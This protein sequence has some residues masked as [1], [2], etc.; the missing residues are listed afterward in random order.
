MPE[1]LRQRP[2]VAQVLW[3][4]LVPAAFGALC[5][6]LLGISEIAYTILTILAIA[7]GYF[8]GF[9]HN[10]WKEGAIRGLVG[11]ALFGAFILIVHDATG[12]SA[13][14]Q[15]PDPHIVLVAITTV[16]GTALGAL[17]GRRR[18]VIIESGAGDRPLFD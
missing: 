6:W 4:T 1:L 3:P 11:G 14:A 12:K 17:G 2:L 13:K 7:G 8:A 15:L 16:F 18:A 10:G 9:E 5:G